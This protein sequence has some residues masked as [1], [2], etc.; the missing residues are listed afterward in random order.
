MDKFIIRYD[1]FITYHMRFTGVSILG[2]WL[3]GMSIYDEDFIDRM[4]RG[5][6]YGVGGFFFGILSPI[7]IPTF[8][9]SYVFDKFQRMFKKK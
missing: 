1:T 9:I 6:G 3:Y 2:G 4:L 5:C 7:I 8:T